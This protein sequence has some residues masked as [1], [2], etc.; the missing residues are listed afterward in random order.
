MAV[1]KHRQEI[2]EV[3]QK[4]FR[5]N[6]YSPTLK[7]LCV[8]LGRSPEGRATVQRWLQTM[9]GK[10]VEWEDNTARSLRLLE[11]KSET[12][13]EVSVVETLRYLSTGLAQWEVRT[14][15]SQPVPESLRLGLSRAYL[16]SLLEEENVSSDSIAPKDLPEFFKW[17]SQPFKEWPPSEAL[18]YLAEDVRL[19]DDSLISDFALQW[20]LEGR[21][22]ERQ[23]QESLLLD[24]L[25]HCRQY[26]EEKAYREF[27]QLIISRPVLSYRDYRRVLASP[28]L[29]PLKNFVR[30]AYGDLSKLQADRNY[31]LCPRCK[32]PQRRRAEGS[33]GCRSPQCDRIRIKQQLAPLPTISPDEA[34][35][36]KAVTPGIH[37]YGTIPGLWEIGLH[38]QLSQLGIQSTLW[39]EI[40]EYDLLIDFGY[41]RRWAI[42]VKDWSYL[43]LD[44]LKAVQFRSDVKKTYVVFPDANEEQ[45]RIKVLRKRLEP[46]LRGVRLRL[47]SEIVAEAK[48]FVKGE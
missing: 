7:E 16:S 2:L 11:D 9:R 24:V 40:D 17:A 4:W 10:D 3:L 38:K 8:E 41:R 43:N 1:T 26:Q 33:Y 47:I 36:Y 12:P 46:D 25:R 6:D 34:E 31:H 20:Q 42:D 14:N 29:K 27:R 28:I 35:E 30:E 32:Y 44:R 48:S 45:L 37:R 22:T 5:E 23:V 19:V 13:F 21:D 18:K 39:P 15:E